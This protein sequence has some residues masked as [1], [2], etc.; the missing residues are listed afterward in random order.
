MSKRDYYE[1]LGVS[2]SAETDEI[3]KSYRKLAMKYHPD[4]NPGDKAS[5]E[6]FKEAAEA[7]EV[8]SS[9]EKRQRYNQVGHAGMGGASGGGRGHGGMDMDDIFSQFSDIFGSGGG[10]GRGQQR[11][12]V[13]KGTNLRIKL[14]LNLNEIATGIEKKIK[15][16]K[17]V[18]CTTCSGSGAASGKG[19]STCTTCKGHG[20]V[21]RL[22]NTMLGQMQTT[23]TCPTCAGEGK[24]IT[25]K[26]K[27][28]AGE[29]I[30]RGEEQISIQ[31]PAGVAEGMQLNVSGK[32]NA[33]A[34]GGING[35]LIVLIEEEPHAV[36]K[37]DGNNLIYEHYINFADAVLGSSIE[38]PTV[39]GKASVKL[40]AGIQSGKIL[41]LRGKGLPEVQSYNKGDLLVNIN[42][43]T[44]QELNKEEKAILE[45]LRTSENFRPQ[46]TGK[47]KGFFERMKEM[48]NH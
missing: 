20:Q 13:N 19:F 2:R 46:P 38:V 21:T 5:E 24:I 35:D 29:G 48:F 40:D 17:F 22:V 26:C 16:N 39:D 43:W 41:R 28:C 37:R 23:Q 45:K 36:L 18:N 1:V 8:L 44:P 14:K 27:P 34:R 33:A 4:K 15:V 9:A 12:R 7:Y 31:V 25:D 32:G 10:G 6:K 47:E 3:K 30:V 11:Q 42:I